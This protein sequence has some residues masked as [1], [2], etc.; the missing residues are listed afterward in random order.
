MSS[1][2]FNRYSE[3]EDFEALQE[4]KLTL[5][6]LALYCFNVNV[7]AGWWTDIKTG[8]SLVG[9]RNIPELLCLAHSELSE[10]LE[11][12]RK[13]LMDDKL[14]DRK[15]LEVEIGDCIIRL[16]DICGSMG[17]DIGGA[18]VEKIVY[19]KHREDHK[20]EQR[21]LNNGKKF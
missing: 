3:D 20:I 4:F 1:E 21:K 6:A 9:K 14:P 8:E 12:Y 18:I 2:A 15:M 11:G 10:G 17:L 19:N 7:K 16:M 5:N 13:D